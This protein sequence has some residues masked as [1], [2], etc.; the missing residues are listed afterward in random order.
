MMCSS[1]KRQSTDYID[2][3]LRASERSRVE[4]H[5]R[6]CEECALEIDQL[7]SVRSSLRELA[8]PVPPAGLRTKLQVQASRERQAL[9]ESNW[10]ILQRVWNRWMFRLDQAMRPITLPATGGLLASIILFAGLANMISTTT[11]GVTYEV[12]V[13]YADHTDP[14][15]VPVELRSAVVL[16]LSL[17]STGRIRDYAV[18]DG[19]ASFVGDPTRLQADN[20]S[21][22]EFPGVLALA[23][24]TNRDI[25][26]SFIPILFRH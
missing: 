14:N 6:E 19:S 3:R 12:P 15:L 16:T 20:I 24:P 26:I 10:S 7:A 21:M 22:P 9:L 1:V 4:A 13:V 17:D 23:Q 25:S 18:Q 11:R 2:G 5:L 8:Q